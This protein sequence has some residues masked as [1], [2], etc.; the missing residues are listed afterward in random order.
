[1]WSR[2]SSFCGA[3]VLAAL[4]PG[5]NVFLVSSFSMRSGF[6]AGALAAAGVLAANLT[7]AL[8]SVAGLVTLLVGSR[9]LFDLVRLCG[10]GYLVWIGLGLM[11]SA[12]RPRQPDHRPALALRPSP[13]VQGFA[14]HIANPKGILYWTALL[15][16]FVP[17][18]G[19][20][21]LPL[22]ALFGVTGSFIEF[23]VLLG[24]AHGAQRLRHF[25][26]RAGVARLVDGAAGLLF[27]VAGTLL[28]FKTS[29]S[30]R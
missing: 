13:L 1:M 17:P 16:Q 2:T 10:A 21:A 28:G 22:L 26:E 9:L 30:E 14:T 5:L 27:A 4:S 3:T 15:P 19:E 12:L 29:L 18:G 6:R 25:V 20:H 8:V 7:Y 11:R 23:A 24:Y